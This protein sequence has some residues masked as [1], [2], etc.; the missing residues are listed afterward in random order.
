MWV[1]SFKPIYCTSKKEILITINKAIDASPE[2]RDKKALIETFISRINEV[3]DIMTEWHDYV[4][5][6]SRLQELTLIS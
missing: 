5:A 4:M 3:E 6:T 1:K 2:L